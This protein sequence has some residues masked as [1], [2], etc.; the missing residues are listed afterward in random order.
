M[1]YEGWFSQEM[2]S[3]VLHNVTVVHHLVSRSG[4]INVN[5][6]QNTVYSGI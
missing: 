4:C 5:Q 6:K 3:S 2:R 1:K